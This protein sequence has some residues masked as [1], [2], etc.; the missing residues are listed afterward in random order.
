MAEGGANQILPAA[1]AG[2]GRKKSGKKTFAAGVMLFSGIGYG[3]WRTYF[4]PRAANS[5]DQQKV[6]SARTVLPLESFTVNL[7]DQEE[8]RFLRATLSLGV[9][10]TLPAISKG[11]SKAIETSRVSMATIRDSILSILTQCKSGDLL[12]P[13]GK[14]KLKADLIHSLNRDV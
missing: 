7:A 6:S 8:G 12:T 3:V 2:R 1:V 9:D 13:E 5:A 11:E 10:G 14:S 4:P